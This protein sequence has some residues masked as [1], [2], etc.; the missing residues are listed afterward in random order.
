METPDP[1]TPSA[2]LPVAPPDPAD[3]LVERARLW[4]VE[5]DFA[6]ARS[7]LSEAL[8][9][10]DPQARQRVSQNPRLPR[11]GVDPVALWTSLACAVAWLI[12]ATWT[13]FP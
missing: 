3:E 9:Q 5:G 10:L 6:C 8:A 12:I 2:Q 11:L 4:V 13:L 7:R 1:D